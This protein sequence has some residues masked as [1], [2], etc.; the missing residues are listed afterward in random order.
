MS[1][2]SIIVN[3]MECETGEISSNSFNA[4]CVHSYTNA[5]TFYDLNSN[6]D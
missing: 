6:V 3:F 5:L 2:G 4:G 1:A